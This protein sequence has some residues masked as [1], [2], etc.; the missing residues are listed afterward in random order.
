[1]LVEPSPRAGH[2][3]G[4][5][6]CNILNSHN[7]FE[8]VVVCGGGFTPREH[9]TMSGAILGCRTNGRGAATGI[10]WVEAKDAS[11]I[12]QRITWPKMPMVPRWRSP[13]LS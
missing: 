2:W 5:F 8:S 3:T 4:R 11:N 12:L 9:V 13:A 1:M 6:A 7:V 10:E